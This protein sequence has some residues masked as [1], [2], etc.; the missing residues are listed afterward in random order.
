MD[1]LQAT[2]TCN[3]C[4]LD[5]SYFNAVLNDYGIPTSETPIVMN[6]LHDDSGNVDNFTIDTSS[7]PVIPDRNNYFR[8]VVVSKTVRHSTLLIIN[9]N[10][11]SWWNPKRSNDSSFSRRLH[12]QLK[13]LIR[14]YVFSSGM[15]FNEIP[16]NINA[17]KKPNCG[18]CNAY[19]LK[20]VLCTELGINFTPSVEG[21]MCEIIKKYPKPTTD[22]IE[23]DFSPMGGLVGAAAGGLVAGPTGL[24]AGGLLGGLIAG[25][26]KWAP[27]YD[28]RS[29]SISESRWY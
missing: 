16:I 18:F 9:N 2:G 19:V 13:T 4:Y 10:T 21:F 15:S 22:D 25:H 27:Q 3:V 29:H 8:L 26:S 14:E 11:A 23:Y 1:L 6:I 28:T 20:Y 5:G 17:E 7:R 24:L 12:A